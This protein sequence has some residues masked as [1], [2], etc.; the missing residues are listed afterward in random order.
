M[1]Q[2]H[3]A[4]PFLRRNLCCF[5]CGTRSRFQRNS[6]IRQFDCQQCEATNYLDE[7]GE[8]TDPPVATEPSAP[9]IYAHFV[10]GRVPSPTLNPVEGSLFCATCIQNQYI[11]NQTLAS[12]LPPPE[13]PSFSKFEKSLPEYK[14]NLEKRYPQVCRD[15]APRV[16]DRI[17]QTAHA[18]KADHVNRLLE[19]AKTI[20]I[21]KKSMTWTWQSIL[22]FWA[23]LLW[24]SSI[25]GH[26]VWSAMGVFAS[27]SILGD[28]K[29]VQVFN[30]RTC[31][32]QARKYGVMQSECVSTWYPE[33]RNIMLLAL[34]TFWWNNKLA[35]RIDS[36]RGRLTGL[37]DHL[38]LQVLM[39]IVRGTTW[40]ILRDPAESTLPIDVYRAVH[41]AVFVF[42]FITAILSSFM[43]KIDKTP[44]ISLKA[45]EPLLTP[46]EYSPEKQQ[47]Y[48]RPATATSFQSQSAAYL[49]PFPVN[50]LAQPLN[51]NA[52]NIDPPS[53]VSCKSHQ[54]V[55]ETD[56]TTVRPEVDEDTMEWTPT[57][58]ENH[59]FTL[60]SRTASLPVQQQSNR[61]SS[62]LQ[63]A[64][65]NERNPFRGTL[66]PAPLA[67]AHKLRNP[68][69][70]P[71]FQQT[72]AAKQ[73]DFFA[74]IMNRGGK[75][76]DSPGTPAFRYENEGEEPAS[77]EFELAPARLQLQEDAVDTGLE[78]LFN[79]VFSIRDE[80]KEVQEAEAR[81]E[82]VEAERRRRE[83]EE[84]DGVVFALLFAVP[85]IIIGVAFVVRTVWEFARDAIASAS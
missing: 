23:G 70:Q 19:R 18:A 78:S 14:K 16:R 75:G 69:N 34:A 29:D 39:L 63:N 68:P 81:R 65:T 41:A 21:A 43:V 42:I 6:Q 47:P 31:I 66:P 9:T 76:L 30:G 33:M 13:D 7:K 73:R 35:V 17:K 22:V 50:R 60:D 8:I 77:R 74:R 26:L 4:M 45:P 83:E 82:R 28:G 38:I 55:T 3:S 20:G 12:Y 84:D 59:F 40:W 44:R 72:S 52:Q 37:K 53:P 64:T 57:K 62:L 46:S 80:P 15:C 54:T 85:P 51:L 11:V 2:H 67:P 49:K 48:S 10:P 24:W 25:V 71:I 32:D 1:Q 36:S 61:M 56:A 58:P 27:P 5:Y 79:S